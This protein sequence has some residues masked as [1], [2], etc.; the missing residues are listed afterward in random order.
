MHNSEIKKATT[1]P[2]ENDSQK[3]IVKNTSEIK[4]AFDPNIAITLGERIG[5]DKLWADGIR[6]ASKRYWIQPQYRFVSRWSE[7]LWNPR[8][9]W[10][11]WCS[12]GGYQINV[13]V[14]PNMI[15]AWKDIKTCAKDPYCSAD[16]VG[17]QMIHV[18]GCKVDNN[19]EITNP[20]CLYKHNWRNPRSYYP[21][22][23]DKWLNAINDILQSM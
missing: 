12:F 13:C 9:V 18:Y 20:E 21:P 2:K 19:G 4:L 7:N 1:L 11:K 22:R 16:W 14:R 10:D 17:G 8:A 3:W 5:I 23:V 15:H 6:E